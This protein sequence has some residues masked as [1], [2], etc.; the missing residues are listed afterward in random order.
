MRVATWNINH[1]GKQRALRQGELLRKL[2]PDLILLQEANPRSAQALRL[3]AGADWLIPASDLMARPPQG[4]AVANPRGAAIAGRGQRP[5][6]A[7]LQ[8]D[9]HVP[10]RILLAPVTVAGREL[11]AVS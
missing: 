9:V 5:G 8:P 10:E 11:T 1:P 2:E 3:A 4:R 6:P 7:W